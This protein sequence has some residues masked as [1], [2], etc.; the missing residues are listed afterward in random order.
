[1]A[2][3]TASSLFNTFT[4]AAVTILGAE[5]AAWDPTLKQNAVQ[6]AGTSEWTARV[7]HK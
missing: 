1:M 5:K 6:G 3:V 4:M 2:S 7:P